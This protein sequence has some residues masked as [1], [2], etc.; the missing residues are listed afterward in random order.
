[1]WLNII[2]TNYLIKKWVFLVNK[3]SNTSHLKH[4]KNAFSS[5]YKTLNL[6]F[7]NTTL[8][9][10]KYPHPWSNFTG[11]TLCLEFL[12]HSHSAELSI[13]WVSC[14]DTPCISKFRRHFSFYY[15]KWINY[16]LISLSS[17]DTYQSL[18]SGLE[19]SGSYVSL[20]KSQVHFSLNLFSS[21]TYWV[22]RCTW[23]MSLREKSVWLSE[24]LS[25]WSAMET[26]ALFPD[27]PTGRSKALVPE[28]W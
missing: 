9:N 5:L 16:R 14:N 11:T 2:K 4:L 18:V 8:L 17:I 19:W 12:L 7:Y 25:G 3:C 21:P 13:P 6:I 15:I 26:E 22:L 10:C 23:I 20:G 1:M 24:L 27:K 28:L